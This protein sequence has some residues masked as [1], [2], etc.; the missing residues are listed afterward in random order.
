MTLTILLAVAPTPGWAGFSPAFSV[1][2]VFATCPSATPAV[3]IDADG[4]VV[5]AWT[6]SPGGGSN[7][8]VQARTRSAAGTFGPILNVSGLSNLQPSPDLAIDDSGDALIAWT[9][10]PLSGSCHAQ[11]RAL[12]AAGQLGPITNLSNVLPALF[13]RVAMNGQGRA[14][15]AWER[16][17]QSFTTRAIEARTRSV[18]GVLGPVQPV[19]PAGQRNFLPDV[20]MNANNE[21]V[22]TWV[23]LFGSDRR[24]QARR[25]SASG[26]FGLVHLNPD[27]V[28]TGP[29]PVA[30]DADGDAVFSWTN[31]SGQVRMRTLSAADALGPR[32]PVSQG[33]QL[34]SGAGLGQ[35]AMNA[36][37]DAIFGFGQL[38]QDGSAFDAKARFRSAGGVFIPSQTLQPAGG[39][40]VAG[41]AAD[42]RS[43]FAWFRQVGEILRVEARA[44]SAIGDLGPVRVL[45]L[46][47]HSASVVFVAM[48]AGGEAAIAWCDRDEEDNRRIFGA[49]FTP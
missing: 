9:L 27:L 8:R 47:G 32:Q 46:A 22:F 49:T 3:A 28:G 40:P 44:R 33:S 21:A 24:V 14:I 4:D 12:S 5:F 30:I 39:F 35:L 37:G 29:F 19:S 23:R 25:R 7:E 15:F 1:S 41:I 11:F 17:N 2:G 20:D 43:L 31:L 42:G 34:A 13:A 36:A 16:P 18:G 48:N 38:R 26:E 6:Q 45:S 10:C